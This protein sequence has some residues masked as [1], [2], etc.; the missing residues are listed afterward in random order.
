LQELEKCE[1]SPLLVGQYFLRHVSFQWRENKFK[2]VRF[3]VLTVVTKLDCAVS[4]IVT[5][6]AVV[7]VHQSCG[8]NYCLHL[9][10]WRVGKVGSRQQ[11]KPFSL[12][13]Y[14]TYSLTLK[15]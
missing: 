2:L 3:E 13:F 4:C 6:C 9:Q 1:S 15:M 10:G 11:M 14:S 12:A 5:L 8:R 7:E